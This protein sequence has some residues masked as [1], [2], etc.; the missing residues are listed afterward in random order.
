[1][2]FKMYNPRAC[3]EVCSSAVCLLSQSNN[4]WQL[5]SASAVENIFISGFI[6]T[7]F[8]S[9][10]EKTSAGRRHGVYDRRSVTRRR[11]YCGVNTF[12]PATQVFMLDSPTDGTNADDGAWRRD[13]WRKVQKSARAPARVLHGPVH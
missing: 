11:G 13:L 9:F 8:C 1:M 5:D 7:P 12:A 3:D 2:L 4:V 6:S 10:H